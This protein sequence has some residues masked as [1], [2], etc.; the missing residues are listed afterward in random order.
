MRV[1]LCVPIA[2]MADVDRELLAGV[3]ITWW[4]VS[5]LWDDSGRSLYMLSG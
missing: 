3:D 1:L 5:M 4:L 2:S